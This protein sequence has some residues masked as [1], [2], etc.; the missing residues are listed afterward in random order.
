MRRTAASGAISEKFRRIM[1]HADVWMLKA[2]LDEKGKDR[3]L[4]DQVR[5]G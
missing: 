4:A 5:A 3:S 1:D 2:A